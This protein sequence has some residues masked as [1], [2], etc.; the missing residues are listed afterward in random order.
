MKKMVMTVALLVAVATGSTWAQSDG[1]TPG[2]RPTPTA[3]GTPDSKAGS[4]PT[5]SGQGKKSTMSAG[6]TS[7]QSGSGN[8]GNKLGGATPQRGHKSGTMNKQAAG[9]PT[10]SGSSSSSANK[11]KQNQ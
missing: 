3:E 1:S 6:S 2:R 8:E 9:V 5:T 10:T 7:S 4:Q 11:P